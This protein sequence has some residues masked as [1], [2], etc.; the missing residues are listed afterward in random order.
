MYRK[1]V[2]A[3]KAFLNALKYDPE[4]KNILRDLSLLQ[5]WMRDF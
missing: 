5:I 3:R 2:E 1:P 4:N